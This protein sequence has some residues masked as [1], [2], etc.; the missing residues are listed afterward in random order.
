MI[1]YHLSHRQVQ[2]LLTKI[3]I[4]QRHNSQTQVSGT[5]VHI[6]HF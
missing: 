4:S 6:T 1:Y 5:I 2:H 3:Q